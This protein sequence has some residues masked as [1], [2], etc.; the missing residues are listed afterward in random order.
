MPSKGTVV[1]VS[2]HA[3]DMVVED[4][5]GRIQVTDPGAAAR[6]RV[7]A[8][9]DWL[10]QGP[11]AAVAHADNEL[12]GLAP[13]AKEALKELAGAVASLRDLVVAGG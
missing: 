8:L 2:Q 11:E 3:K 12:A 13:A 10:K 9:P 7:E 1:A 5:D 6:Q 4:K